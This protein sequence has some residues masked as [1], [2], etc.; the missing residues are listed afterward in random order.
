LFSYINPSHELRMREIIQEEYPGASV[1][2]SHEVYPRWREYDRTSSTL[3]DAFLKPRISSYLENLSSGLA[4]GGM[5]GHFLLMKSNGG[6]EDHRAAVKRPIDLIMSG[7]VGGVLSA[8]YFG[9]ITAR[10]NL[11]AMDM[12]GTSFDVS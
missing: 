10:P 6:M 11:I 8:I 2:L 9:Q 4:R 12:G 5:D 1:S 7:P 3:A